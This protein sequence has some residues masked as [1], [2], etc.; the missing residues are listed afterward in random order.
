MKQHIVDICLITLASITYVFSYFFRGSIA[1]ITDV[2][3]KEFNAT[4]SQ[5]GF[6]SSAFWLSYFVMQ[7]PSGIMVQ[8][9][10]SEF[11]LTVSLFVFAIL[12]LIFG[13]PL[14]SDQVAIP[15]VLFIICGIF[16]APMLLCVMS[17]IGNRMGSNHVP[18][19]GGI[20]FFSASFFLFGANW[21]QAFLYQK[22]ALWRPIYLVLGVIILIAAILFCTLNRIDYR[23]RSSTPNEVGSVRESKMVLINTE[24]L[25]F[26]RFSQNSEF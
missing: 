24:I 8:Y 11:I 26:Q 14:N 22:Y 20:N 6:M 4:S 2:F 15:T 19:I 10:T 5:I 21:F 18:F 16:V 12:S 3:E 9:L 1:P 13:L 25:N 23:L 17:M 7:I